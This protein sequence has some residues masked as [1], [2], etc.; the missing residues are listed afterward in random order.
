M[1]PNTPGPVADP[2]KGKP[3]TSTAARIDYHSHSSGSKPMILP[4]GDRAHAMWNQPPSGQDIRTSRGTEYVFAMREHK[5]YVYN[6]T[7]VIAT[8]P[9]GS[10]K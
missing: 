1:K 2:T 10:I 3:G 6:R 4:N 7:G 9:M 8:I 5:V